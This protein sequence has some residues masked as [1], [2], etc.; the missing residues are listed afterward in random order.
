[1]RKR[2]LGLVVG[3]LTLGTGISVQ[4]APIL[5]TPVANYKKDTSWQNINKTTYTFADANANNRVDIG[6]TVSF[7]VE[8]GKVYWGRHDFDAMKVWVRPVNDPS[9]NLYSDSK[10]W[11]F[12]SGNNDDSYSYLPWNGGTKSYTF[13]YTFANAGTYNFIASVICSDDLSGLVGQRNG[14]PEPADWR[15]W[16]PS[17]HTREGWMQGETELYKLNVHEAVPEPGTMALLLLG[18]AGMGAGAYRRRK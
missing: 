15:A 14:T 12:G 9:L 16:N 5:L 18:L 6:E 1:M 8:M 10:I 7:T 2:S 11:N 4:A 13:D 3:L 17:V